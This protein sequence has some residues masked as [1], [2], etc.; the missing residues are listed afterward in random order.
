MTPACYHQ[1]HKMQAS[2]H[3]THPEPGKKQKD[4]HDGHAGARRIRAPCG[5]SCRPGTTVQ[6]VRSQ[7]TEDGRPGTVGGQWDLLETAITVTECG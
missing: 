7:R 5:D 6:V 3:R 1:A 2:L 4:I